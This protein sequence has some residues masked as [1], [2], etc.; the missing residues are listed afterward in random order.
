MGSDEL[1]ITAKYVDKPKELTLKDILLLIEKLEAKYKNID[2]DQDSRISDM[3]RKIDEMEKSVKDSGNK[4]HMLKDL[5]K[6]IDGDKISGYFDKLKKDFTE[7]RDSVEDMKRR[8]S[9][10][11][12]SL[13]RNDE[14]IERIGRKKGS[15][16]YD[17]MNRMLDRINNDLKR[18]E[19]DHDVLQ[20]KLKD[21]S[22]LSARV[23]KVE[24]MPK[25]GN[26]ARRI[27]ELAAS[28]PDVSEI[29]DEIDI[30]AKKFES[31]LDEVRKADKD[32]EKKILDKIPDS[33]DLEKRIIA[34]EGKVS[35]AGKTRPAEISRLSRSL[36]TELGKIQKMIAEM[37]RKHAALE[38]RMGRY[39]ILEKKILSIEK[40]IPEPFDIYRAKIPGMDDLSK[41]MNVLRMDLERLRKK[42]DPKIAKLSKDM[43]RNFD[44]MGKNLA[45]IYAAQDDLG[46]R[47]RE[48]EGLKN[49]MEKKINSFEKM[50]EGLS[51]E[52]KSFAEMKS[53]ASGEVREFGKLKKQMFK[54]LKDLSV[55]GTR[56]E[57]IDKKLRNLEIDSRLKTLEALKPGI[58]KTKFDVSALGKE[59]FEIKKKS[60]DFY[61]NMLSSANSWQG[62]AERMIT[63]ME[64][65]LDKR[66][67]EVEGDV[68]KFRNE[69]ADLRRT[70]DTEAAK[71]MVSEAQ[72]RVK[73]M[74]YEI[75]N[76]SS[77]I[78]KVNDSMEGILKRITGLEEFRDSVKEEVIEKDLAEVV[79]MAG[80]V[81]TDI[82]ALKTD[83]GLLDRRMVRLEKE[84]GEGKEKL[85][86]DMDF[87]KGR[88]KTIEDLHLESI[89][90]HFGKVVTGI[91][92][93]QADISERLE[94]MEKAT[95]RGPPV[96][97][98]ETRR[99]VRRP[100]SEETESVKKEMEE[101]LMEATENLESGDLEM[102]RV[103]HDH[104]LTLYKKI[105]PE[106]PESY[107]QKV[108]S[109]INEL[110]E[111]ME[112]SV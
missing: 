5:I 59:Q 76:I 29:H 85:D 111:K 78:S 88:L 13:A 95:G 77:E 87:I 41:R 4:I 2:R 63:K 12:E 65:S 49:R 55:L 66:I 25:A 51:K 57:S 69:L 37:G 94:V 50:E 45:R 16:Y 68:G 73:S 44:E 96:K 40:K 35:G 24:N 52:K 97:F 84:R 79:E 48:M 92:E 36:G 60:G 10:M 9:K 98:L 15:K 108:Y 30:L 101:L 112:E 82:N 42:K 39:G 22:R 103:L 110:A 71:K 21:F 34:V 109:V 105:R 104:I 6:G 99:M 64:N 18:M 43:G 91:R 56:V 80:S 20:K 26:L 90:D 1:E 14:K 53:L 83:F 74:V 81:S 67:L 93:R 75:E 3:N 86:F 19:G 46:G 32:I 58:E 8:L 54:R 27:D 38:K 102:A 72:A 23:E 31:E 17:E 7:S 62:K 106:I 107:S 100:P 28:F 70:T 47:L 11:S 33:G 89:F 61:K